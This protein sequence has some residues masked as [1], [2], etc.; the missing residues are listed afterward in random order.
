MRE[1]STTVQTA[2]RIAGV[3]ASIAAL[4]V[5]NGAWENQHNWEN[6]SWRAAMAVVL[7]ALAVIV[8]TNALGVL[9][10]RADAA[11][12]ALVPEFFRANESTGTDARSNEAVR[13][14]DAAEVGERR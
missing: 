9:Q 10:G 7:F 14:E 3:V 8:E 1:P 11:G 12:E 13:I 4:E 5:L 2:E 6:L